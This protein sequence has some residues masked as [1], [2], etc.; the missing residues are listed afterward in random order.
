M[1]EQL[2]LREAVAMGVG[3]LIGGG[4]FAVLGVAAEIAG[5]AAFLA[6]LIAGGVAMAS[7][8]SYS[9]LTAHFDE[10]GG[11]FTFIEHYTGNETIAGLVGWTLIVGYVGTMAMYAFAFG[12]FAAYLLVGSSH[13]VLR[14]AL[15][16]GIIGLFTGVNVMGVRESGESQDILVYVKV[17]ILLT[18]GLV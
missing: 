16:I 10:E 1:S 17:A 4:I 5:N 11:S 3:G 2:G 14:G 6:Y 12:S 7:G 13:T 15:S 18:F 8:Y 9:R